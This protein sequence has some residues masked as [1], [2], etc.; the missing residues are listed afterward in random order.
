MKNLLSWWRT[1]QQ[2]GDKMYNVIILDSEF[3]EI[4]RMPIGVN[5][6][7]NDAILE[8][9]E[10]VSEHVVNGMASFTGEL[11]FETDG[12]SESIYMIEV[13][14]E[15]NAQTYCKDEIIDE[16]HEGECDFDYEYDG[17]DYDGY[18]S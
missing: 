10:V 14:S 18:D 6:S 5:L 7:D 16:P 12:N 9:Y 15:G 8:F 13:D 1:P 11:I 17:Y 2:S 4:E 3:I